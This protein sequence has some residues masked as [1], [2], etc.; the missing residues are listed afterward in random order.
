MLNSNLNT[1]AGVPEGPAHR[2]DM[3]LRGHWHPAAGHGQLSRLPRLRQPQGRRLR[4]IQVR[5]TH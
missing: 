5:S 1:G 4:Q 2:G 3:G